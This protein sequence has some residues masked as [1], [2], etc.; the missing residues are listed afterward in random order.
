[1]RSILQKI[2]FLLI[3][4]TSSMLWAAETV[5]LDKVSIIV[6]TTD[7]PVILNAIND[8]KDCLQQAGNVDVQVID[9]NAI[10][11]QQSVV[12]WIGTCDDN[13]IKEL[14][15]KNTPLSEQEAFISTS[16]DNQRGGLEI[17]L[18]GGDDLGVQYAVY[19]LMDRLLVTREGCFISDE[20]HYRERPA[21][22]LRGM[23][24]HLHWQYNKSYAL[25]SWKFEDWKEYIDLLARLRFN[26]LQ[27]WSFVG[28][29]PDPLSEGD[30]A[31]LSRLR[32]VVDYAKTE[33]GFE[34]WV[35]E[36]GNNVAETDGGVPIEKREYFQVEVKKDPGDPEELRDILQNRANLYKIVDNADG[37]WILDSDP[38]GY[39]GSVDS[40][41]VNIFVENRKLI[42]RYS[43]NGPSTKMLYWI[44][45][46]WNREIRNGWQDN[47][48]SW[49]NVIR[50][51]QSKLHEPWGLHVCNPNHIRLVQEFGL[52]ERSNFFPYNTIEWEPSTPH[53]TLKIAHI[54]SALRIVRP[55]PQINGAMGNS[56]TPYVQLPNIAYF[57]DRIWSGY[58][59]M[60]GA[61]KAFLR[62]AK[63]FTLIEPERLVS[64]WQAIESS[65]LQVIERAQQQLVGSSEQA[66]MQLS[67][68]AK[69]LIKDL[70]LQLKL[71]E[72][73][74]KAALY[75]EEK[76]SHAL[77]EELTNYARYSLLW[78]QRTNYFGSL[79]PGRGRVVRYPVCGP[80]LWE[81]RD[82]LSN[83]SREEIQ[84]WRKQTEII[85]LQEN[86]NKE[87]IA[88]ILDEI[89]GTHIP[90]KK[91]HRHN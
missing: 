44:W 2:I 70:R 25:R 40:E 20:I 38:G 26:L 68:L 23:Y 9:R 88:W 64:G 83:R 19:E 73:G 42:D 47:P 3:I 74:L 57:G 14:L 21:F 69:M 39:P 90:E 52:L 35:G 85:L 16:L 54:D 10:M 81:L 61:Q 48:K 46:G 60:Y 59:N 17:T 12:I 89:D 56:Q 62:L 79:R 76:S 58:D 86:E 67:P 41:F 72:S 71:R 87:V 1:M 31:F 28:S 36:C 11:K 34:I 49:S 82:K 37:Y 45:D 33:R 55:Y 29:M 75:A 43:L 6:D 77:F 78:Q 53:T 5:H 50:G 32:D 84:Q 7:S 18:T 80:T 63:N 4:I 51:L 15:D 22:R 30:R 66:L 8:L 91:H 24:A 27:I 65:D 13:N